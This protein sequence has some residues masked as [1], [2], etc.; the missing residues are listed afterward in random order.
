MVGKFFFKCT[1]KHLKLT[2][3]DVLGVVN[4]IIIE[5]NLVKDAGG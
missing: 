4:F 3:Y 1:K 2:P 5:R